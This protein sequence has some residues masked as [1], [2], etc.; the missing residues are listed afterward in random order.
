MT[1]RLEQELHAMTSAEEHVLARWLLDHHPQVFAQGVA[2]V[3]KIRA[4]DERK[5]GAR[6]A[7]S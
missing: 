2:V 6:R 1:P 7:P 4:A 5:Q 3:R